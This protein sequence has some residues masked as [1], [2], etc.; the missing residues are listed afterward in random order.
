MYF[1]ASESL[2]NPPRDEVTSGLDAPKKE[3]PY[4]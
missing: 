3:K 1:L 2:V 4:R